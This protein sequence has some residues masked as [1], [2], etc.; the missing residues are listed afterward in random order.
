MPLPQ[1]V[2]IKLELPPT[3]V[4]RLKDVPLLRRRRH[5][6]QDETQTSVYFDTPRSALRKKGL[7]LRVRRIGRRYIQTI[8]AEN[9]GLLDRDEWETDIESE[10]PDLHAARGT[11]LE[12]LL[13]K[14][15]R[16]QLQPVFETKVRRTTYLLTSNGSSIALTL[17]RGRIQAGERAMP[18]CEI[19]I[20]LKRGDK[21]HLFE[22]ARAIGRTTSAELALKSKSQRGYELLDSGEVSAAKAG[23]IRLTP[24]MP[25]RDAFRVIGISCLKH[26]TNNKPALLAGDPDGIHQMRVGLRRLRAALSLF[27][28]IVEGAETNSIKAELRWLT[29]ELGPAREFEVFLTQVVAPVKLRNVRLQGMRALSRELAAQRTAAVERAQDAI[30]SQRFRDLLLNIAAWLEIGAWL[31]PKNALLRERGALA[32]ERQAA[33]QLTRRWKKVREEGRLLTRLNPD[34][35]HK[36]RIRTKKLRY[37][38]EFFETT[39]PGKKISK[40]RETFL[41]ALTK[42]QDR[43]G[44]LNDIAVHE[45]LTKG[46]IATSQASR[47]NKNESERT[48]A[49]GLLTGYEEAHLATVLAAADDACKAFAKVK[50]FWT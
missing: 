34:A 25:T 41:S 6:A 20:E 2:E 28:G 19:E 8:K 26:M 38:T 35:R 14:N 17:D 31:A 49:V 43:L 5:T 50:P 11:A 37:A 27:S 36:L 48:F 21:A 45:H 13:T 1:E 23:P 18:L 4:S 16:R 39:F 33:A 47:Q 46:I 9:G 29:G 32:V 30:R 22:I 44:D 24:D 3:Q 10:T 15:V 40:R 7:T 42:V 12:R